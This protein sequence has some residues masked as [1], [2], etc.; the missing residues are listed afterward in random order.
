MSIETAILVV[1]GMVLTV[2]LWGV[3]CELRD[4]LRVLDEVAEARKKRRTP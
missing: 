1:M 4:N 2:G 3:R